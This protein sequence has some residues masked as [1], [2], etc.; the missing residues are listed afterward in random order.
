MKS[1]IIAAVVLSVL[2]KEAI[3]WGGLFNR[4]S[5]ELL[6]NMGYGGH[7][8]FIQVTIRKTH[9]KMTGYFGAKV[10]PRTLHVR[11]CITSK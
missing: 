5:P 7:G 2:G 8:G 11:L 4:F 6:A 3:A 1:F 9:A 10:S